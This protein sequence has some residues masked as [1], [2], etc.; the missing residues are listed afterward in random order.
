[1]PSAEMFPNFVLARTETPSPNNLLGIKGIGEGGA[2]AATPAFV[3]AVED[4]LSPYG[5]T[6]DLMPLRY[7]DYVKSI[8][9]GRHSP[10]PEQGPPGLH[11]RL[12]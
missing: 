11:D 7:P 3:N 5:T 9:D 12:P 4:A 10:L 2:C 6:V 8:I 1:M